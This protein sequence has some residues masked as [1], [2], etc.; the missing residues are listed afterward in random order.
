MRIS[1]DW[2][3][4]FVETNESA[5]DIADT[6]TMLGLEAENSIELHGLN[7]IVVGEVID[8]IKHP[9]ADRLKLAS[10]DL[11]NNQISEIVC[12]S[13]GFDKSMPD[14]SAPIASEALL[15]FIDT[16]TYLCAA[17]EYYVAVQV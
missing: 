10:I 17:Y 2:L 5:A 15:I 11:G 12:G 4:D 16:S 13:M 9:N 3:K 1:I 8:R 14:I 7:D 6:L